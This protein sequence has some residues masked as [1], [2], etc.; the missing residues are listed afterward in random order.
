MVNASGTNITRSLLN[1]NLLQAHAIYRH[2]CPNCNGSISD[3][4][5]LLKL[6]CEKCLPDE[7][8]MEIVAK[9]DLLGKSRIERL[10]SITQYLKDQRY[11]RDMIREEDELE[12]IE[13]FFKD[14][15][16]G[17]K[18]WSAQRTWARRLIRGESF[19]IIAPT[20]TGKTVFSIIAALYKVISSRE[21]QR[22]VYLV[23]P[24]TPLLLQ[25]FKKLVVFSENLG[26]KICSMDS[27]SENCIRVICIHGKLRKREKEFYYDKLRNNDFDILMS[28]SAFM[29]RHTDVIPRGVFGL[30]VMDDVDAVLRSGRAV[31]RL[32]HIMG[33]DD[34]DIDKGLE[35]LK[36]RSKIANLPESDQEKART[37]IKQLESEIVASRRKIDDAILIVNSATGRPRGVYPK[38]FRIFLNFEAGAKPEAIRNIIDSY[39][40]PPPDRFDD[41]IVEI[42]TM[43][44]DGVLVFVPVDKGI[45]YAEQI[46]RKL[47][48]RGI[49]AGLKVEAFHSKKQASLIDDFAQGKLN[50]LVGV[51]TYYGVIVRGI[52]L[53]E[54]VKYVIFAGVPRHKFTSTMENISP[55][56]LFRM[57]TVIREIVDERDRE[58]VDKLIGRIARKL[59]T[60]SQGALAILRE[61]FVEAL[62]KGGSI[63]EVPLLRDLI[64]AYEIVREYLNRPDIMSKLEKLGDIGLVSENGVL[65]IFI[66][67]VATYIQ[68]SGRCSRLYPGGIT[69]GLSII[70]V[71]DERL[72]NGLVRKLRWVFE[73]FNILDFNKLD[74]NKLVEEIERERE[75][76]KKLIS[77]EILPGKEPELVKT[78][79]L[80]VESPNKART[81]ANFFGKPSLRVIGDGLRVYEVTMGN[82]I[83]NIVATGGHLYELIVEDKPSEAWSFSDLYGV[84]ITRRNDK[85]IF[86]PIYTDIKKCPR[87]HQFTDES[88]KCPRCELPI[89]NANR[90]ISVITALR[91]VA[92]EVDVVLI[93][94][95][96]DSEGEKIA[97]DVRVL[98]E[99]YAE[100]LMRVEFH[101]ITRRAIINAIL[102][103]RD[104]NERLVEAQI[105]RRIED[106]W[107]GFSLS[108]VLQRYAWP[109]YCLEYLY[110]KGKIEDESSSLQVCCKPNRNLS[111]GRVQ[112]PVLGFIIN[113]FNKSKDPRY[114]KYVV[115][116]ELEGGHKIHVTLDYVEADNVLRLNQKGKPS[117]YPLVELKVIDEYTEEVYPPP[118]FTTD[119]LLAE[120]SMQLG[121]S[122]TKTMEIAQDLFEMG[123]ITY[124]RTDSTRVSDT[125]VEIARQYLENRYGPEKTKE[126][127]NPRTW[128]LKG[129]HEAI[130]PTRPIDADHLAELIREGILVVVGKLTRDH[131]KL[132]DLIFR[133]FI[134]SQMKPAKVIKQRL[135]LSFENGNKYTITREFIVDIED[136]GYLEIYGNLKTEFSHQL[137]LGTKISGFVTENVRMIKYPL[138][139]FHDVIKW[140][141]ERGIGRPSTY[142]KIIQ[143][144]IDRGYVKLSKA[145]KALI[146]QRKG[147]SVYSYLV[148]NFG[149]L[150]SDETTQE[151]ERVMDMV[152]NNEVFYQDVLSN[153]YK[154]VVERILNRK[155]QLLDHLREQLVKIAENASRGHIP[156]ELIDQ[157][158]N[159]LGS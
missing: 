98:L 69:K 77:G 82:Y 110:A 21:N 90:K 92:S 67:D 116:I 142:A 71:D 30:I 11:L 137:S 121:F 93:G 119:T 29:H 51:A 115:E 10:R 22:K 65:Y 62:Q 102:N 35:L 126:V 8:L 49:E 28:T 15:T 154:E 127:F 81:I 106:R 133:R 97:W 44:K 58:D 94:T 159:G 95:D 122:T 144:L 4:R 153:I 50:V 46:A 59:R 74:I 47:S 156:V 26:H 148:E 64:K 7:A 72:L 63:E 89:D 78:V 76:V 36:L 147:L 5:L 48:E 125:G 109:I 38:L 129:A 1:T 80:I 140:M 112:T 84:I 107:L 43:L 132:Y 141:K 139:R 88:D 83:L 31:R 37:D 123:F 68:A 39:V 14:A 53:P 118:P 101:E 120:A 138:P 86:I 130:R 96:P 150:V 114:N 136:E 152:E 73:S 87:G 24:T 40:I 54:R 41:T 57:L 105:V 79:L 85:E 9:T 60:M 13:N 145:V 23:F 34:T 91:R 158:I 108:N 134:A 17:L 3:L 117:L 66:P 113:E 61:R 104:F 33:L 20:G 131:F 52:D 128:G 103:P 155:S 99:P 45:D 151:L 111:A 146:I 124:H 55:T 12:K 6:P 135:E 32:L 143:T 70:V 16:R 2:A 75:I 149:N 56:D 157:C 19:S 42:V 100:K 18:M 25:A 27:W